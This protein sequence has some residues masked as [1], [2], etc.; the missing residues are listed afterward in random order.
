ML[1]QSDT[2]SYAGTILNSAVNTW[3]ANNV[4]T[5][6][7]I[8]A[9]YV[10]QSV[11][12]QYETNGTFVVN[13]TTNNAV[14][15]YGNITASSTV[16]S[17]G[18]ATSRSDTYF[19]DTTNWLLGQLTQ[20]QVTGTLPGGVSLTRTIGY[21]SNPTTGLMT[22]QVI[23]P[24]NA[25]LTLTADYGRD[26]FG[27]MNAM[28][29]SGVDIVSR[30][31]SVAYDAQGRFPITFS[32][33]L[34]QTET[35]T[36]DGRFGALS[37]AT[38]A[39]GITTSWTYDSFGRAVGQTLAD[40]S[41]L[42]WNY[43]KISGSP[44]PTNSVYYSTARRG[45]TIAYQTV[46]Y[47][48]LDREVRSVMPSFD[49]RGAISQ[50]TTYDANLRMVNATRPYS[51]SSVTYSASFTY[52]L[53]GRIKTQTAPDASVTTWSYNGFTSGLTNAKNQTY[54]RNVNSQGWLMQATD[55]GGSMSYG[56]DAFGNLTRTTDVAGN[57]IAAT[58]DLRGRKKTTAD[59][60]MGT[61]SYA[62]NAI[63]DLVT[64]TDAKLQATTFTY[65]KLGR[66]LSRVEPGLISSWSYDT[67]LK[68]IGKVA[69]IT[70]NNGFSRAFTYDSLSRVSAVTTNIDGVAYPMSYTYDIMSRV[71]TITYP[72][73]FS[74]KNIYG[75]NG[76]LSA[77]QNPSTFQNYWQVNASDANL[78][79]TQETLGANTTARSFNAAT[80]RLEGIATTGGS[81]GTVQQQGFSYDA[82]GNLLSRTD[83]TQGLSETFGY[84][85]LN[86]L[87]SAT[88][89]GGVTKTYGYNAVGNLTSK[90]DVGSYTYPVTGTVRP[91]AVAAIT[92]TLNGAANPTFSYDANGNLLS[93]AGRSITWT[94]FNLP[95]SVTTGTAG[96]SFSYDA[97]HER[98]KKIGPDGTTVY[99]G[100][101]L[102]NGAH[103]E[104][105]V[106]GGVTS[107]RHYIYAGNRPIA[108]TT[109][110]SNGVNDTRYLHTDHLGSVAAVTDETGAVVERLSYDVFGKRRNPN[111]SDGAAGLTST[112]LRHGYTQQEHLDEA[113]VAWASRLVLN[114]EKPNE[115]RLPRRVR[116][117]HG[118]TV[119]S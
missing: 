65:D 114:E 26:A 27:H 17:D 70:S 56:Y 14:D 63:G 19:N 31:S 109:Q 7:A 75:V 64:Q 90:S 36:Y 71:D 72:T 11:Q 12:N 119:R 78:N 39:N 8:V 77:V 55:A 86:R 67:A 82:L 115:Q 112:Q 61:W 46:C 54:S 44:C 51:S 49:G 84:D 74:V 37:A 68:G 43:V 1:A 101:N 110:R 42:S 21:T 81:S 91:H 35:R 60:D 33:A 106:S 97:N 99:L 41:T 29:V 22:R 93:G 92:G 102:Y 9:P 87:T 62:Y 28:T 24:N 88:G 80:G 69:Q 96:V 16:A 50:D 30:S 2:V 13:Y 111:G 116:E 10:L 38:D 95:A 32:N 25:A 52:D 5:G 47:D 108:I 18:Y 76:Y 3:S 98:F 15:N 100:P 20:R 45:G 58:Y 105:T 34:G 48:A 113:S 57:V 73:G 59:P 66:L 40:G 118:A 6:T 79:V 85:A 23:E 94:A 117:N 53:L 83:L 103:Y 104:K 107:H 4:Y 89:F